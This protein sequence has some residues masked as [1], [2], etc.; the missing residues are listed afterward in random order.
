MKFDIVPGGRA[1]KK[2]RNLNCKCR[3]GNRQKRRPR[4]A[5]A[6]PGTGRRRGGA[7]TSFGFWNCR[8]F[9]PCPAL[10]GDPVLSPCTCS[11]K[12][13]PSASVICPVFRQCSR[14]LISISFRFNIRETKSEQRWSRILQWGNRPTELKNSW[15]RPIVGFCFLRETSSGYGG[16]RESAEI[17]MRKRRIGTRSIRFRRNVVGAIQRGSHLVVMWRL[18][19]RVRAKDLPALPFRRPPHPAHAETGSDQRP[20]HGERR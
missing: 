8:Q 10:T 16:K 18:G 20:A 1:A 5:F 6:F 13:L 3:S 15:P 9:R 4:Y 14:T 11:H 17:R 19:A 7:A 12:P 2:E